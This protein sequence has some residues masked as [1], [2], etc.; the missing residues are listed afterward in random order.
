MYSLRRWRTWHGESGRLEEGGHL[1]VEFRKD[2]EHIT[3][4]HVYSHN[5]AY[6]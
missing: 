5:D 1:T 2:A 4:H 6:Q 3:T